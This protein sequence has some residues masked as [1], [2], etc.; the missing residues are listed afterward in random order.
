MIDT[1]NKSL[2]YIVEYYQEQGSERYG[3]AYTFRGEHLMTN[4][5]K[6]IDKPKE[7]R[8]VRTEMNLE[9]MIMPSKWGTMISKVM[10]W[11]R[12]K[13]YASKYEYW[14]FNGKDILLGFD[15]HGDSWLFNSCLSERP[16]RSFQLSSQR[17]SI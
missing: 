6:K 17:I 4:I 10:K 2:N 11:P 8:L 7:L 5:F 3:H 12:N 16:R 15:E 9:V 1:L 14:T 13:A